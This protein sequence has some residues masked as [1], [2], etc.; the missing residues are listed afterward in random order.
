MAIVETVGH[1]GRFL[2]YD[3]TGELIPYML[4]SI[5]LLLVPILFAASLYMTLG[6]VIRALDGEQYFILR[7][8]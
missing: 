1:V 6:R 5:F 2:A 4:Q 3:K 7:L 8:K